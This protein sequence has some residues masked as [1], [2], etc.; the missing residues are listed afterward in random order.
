[1]SESQC[2]RARSLNHSHNILEGINCTG[3][4]GDELLLTVVLIVGARP[5]GLFFF[6][7][8]S[9]CLLLFVVI[10]ADTLFILQAVTRAAK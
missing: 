6:R 8:K 5:S 7:S 9:P 10:F 4:T 3:T 1:M 2:V